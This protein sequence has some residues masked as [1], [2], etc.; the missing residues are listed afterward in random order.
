M[1][2][3]PLCLHHIGE[4]LVAS[5][6]RDLLANG[7]YSEIT[8]RGFGDQTV[9]LRNLLKSHDFAD[10][11]NVEDHVSIQRI[12]INNS[13][14]GVDGESRIDCLLADKTKGMGMEIKLG[15]TR[16]TTGAFQK[17][18]LMPCKKDKHEPPRVSGSMIAILDK[19][20]DS[21]DS[22][23]EMQEK[24][25][26]DISASYEGKSLPMSDTWLLMVRQKV[27]EK[28]KFGKTGPVIRACHVLIFEE[29][30]KL[31]GGGTRFN[32]IVSDLIGNDFAEDWKLID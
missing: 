17:R 20:F 22:H 25:K 18:F 26:V 31:L 8:C 12:R 1:K 7:K 30:V 28:W 19:R 5:I 9:S 21:F 14:Y 32:Q 2:S 6:M 4:P 29:I 15:T 23:L 3:S 13:D 27:W 11:L 10:E 24:D 16:M